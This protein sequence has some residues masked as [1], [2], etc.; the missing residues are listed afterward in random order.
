MRWTPRAM[1]RCTGRPTGARSRASGSC[2]NTA[3]TPMRGFAGGASGA[4]RRAL[5]GRVCASPRAGRCRSMRAT[6]RAERRFQSRAGPQL[7]AASAEVRVLRRRSTTPSS[8]RSCARAARRGRGP[9]RARRR[10]PHGFGGGRP[11]TV[12]STGGRA[13]AGA[14]RRFAARAGSPASAAGVGGPRRAQSLPHR[15]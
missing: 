1:A 15:A 3:S 5:A 10:G 6:T 2:G 12:V 9:E 7:L 14:G 13:A 8:P 11:A 4:A